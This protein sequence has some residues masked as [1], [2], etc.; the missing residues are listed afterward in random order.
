MGNDKWQM[1][2]TSCMHMS[3][4]ITH[5]AC[6][7]WGIWRFTATVV[8][9]LVL[10]WKKSIFEWRYGE[11]E[12]CEFVRILL[13]LWRGTDRVLWQA[14]LRCLWAVSSSF[15]V[16]ERLRDHQWVWDE[17][18]TICDITMQFHLILYAHD[19]FP[20]LSWFNISVGRVVFLRL[21]V[22]F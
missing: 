15:T 12:A 9:L 10:E 5:T 1:L 14:V 17:K 11:V 13:S 19:G 22:T 2:I 4:V 21:L 3:R 8:Y 6:G 7:G 16:S 20:C 18:G